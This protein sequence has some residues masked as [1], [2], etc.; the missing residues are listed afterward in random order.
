[1]T[2]T[3]IDI[4]AHLL[5][6]AAEEL[7]R[8]AAFLVADRERAAAGQNAASRRHNAALMAGQWGRD[9]TD[10]PS[11]FAAME[12]AGVGV[13]VLSVA[14]SQYYYGAPEALSAEIVA[15][16]NEHLAA[17]AA[18]HP[19]RLTAMATVSLQAPELAAAQL[20]HAAA[21]YG[22][23]AVMISSWAGGRDLSDPAYEPL[24]ATA[25]R[26]EQLVFIHPLGCSLGPRLAD[27]YLS[28]I[29]GQPVETTVALSH[30]IFGGVLD[31]HPGLRICAAHGGG[32]LPFYIGRS[33]HGRT[34]RPESRTPAEPPSAYLHRL[35][36]DTVVHRPDTLRALVAAAG[37]DRLLLGTDY[38]YDMGSTDPLGLLHAADLGAD[39]VAAIAGGTAAALLRIPDP[40]GGRHGQA[41]AR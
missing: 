20:E 35:Y 16:V 29:V 18:A 22:M 24:W 10:L 32:Y 37:A 28:N 21:T 26:L 34:V 23:R 41:S 13:Q 11:R 3:V 9:L 36:Y 6:P 7:V 33:D 4:H 19:D 12:L 39:A 5:V 8:G 38:P 27:H 30:L 2:A 25:E 15:A 17:T 1:V 31:R 14:P 40:D